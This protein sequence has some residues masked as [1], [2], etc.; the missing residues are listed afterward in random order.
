MS[1]TEV[2]E[3]TE[4]PKGLGWKLFSFF[5]KLDLQRFALIITVLL[6]LQVLFGVFVPAG[7]REDLYS[8]YFAK[9]VI[10]RF[11]GYLGIVNWAIGLFRTLYVHRTGAIKQAL[12]KRPWI[13]IFA[14]L[15]FWSLLMIS[16]AVDKNLA[17]FGAAYRFEGFLSYLA[18]AGI[19]LNASM[20]RSEKKITA[21]F[22]VTAVSSG[23]LAAL[24]LMRELLGMSFIMFRAGQVYD[25]SGTFI[26]SNHYG[27]YL[28]VTLAVLA[29]AFL[30]AK[31]LWSKIVLGLI[32]A[33]NTSVLLLNGSFGSFFAALVGLIL[34][35]VLFVIRR[36]FKGAWQLLIPIGA[37]LIL[38]V[39]LSGEK[40]L[41]DIMEF[42][43]ITADAFGSSRGMLW[44]K[45]VAIILNNPV[46]GVGTDNIQLYLVNNIPHNEFLQ[47]ASTLGFP[48]L[49]LYL[50]ALVS[51]FAAAMKNLKKLG[52]CAVI[53]GT[54]VFVYGVSSFV[55]ISIPVATYQ[56]F[57]YLGLLNSWFLNRDLTSLNEEALKALSDKQE[58]V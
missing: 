15:L 45:T 50:A 53:A 42:G 34:L 54:A 56:L 2:S 52:D 6:S 14:V 33:L 28:C 35:F 30:T 9:A 18:Y 49:L 17:F 47:I 38:S 12:R 22:A 37:F 43:N 39:V 25:Y 20:I 58:A 51:L 57:L 23:I 36:G 31:K 4:A 29:G 40:L 13:P 44:K 24:T 41:A 1:T 48:G 16:R 26:N 10:V 5:S 27:Y 11:L 21:L 3:K 46:F 8:L 7:T 32:F 19:L 55:G